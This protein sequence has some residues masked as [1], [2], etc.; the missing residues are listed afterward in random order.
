MKLGVA[1]VCLFGLLCNCLGQVPQTP[2][3]SPTL[4][5]LFFSGNQSWL[6]G[7]KPDNPSINYSSEPGLG[8]KAGAALHH[9]ISPRFFIETSLAYVWE[10][11]KYRVEQVGGNP[12]M[13]L[14]YS[15]VHTSYSWLE[16][17]V[18]LNF[19]FQHNH[20]LPFF[21]GMGISV[22]RLVNA[23]ADV[24]ALLG[25]GFTMHSTL[26]PGVDEWNFF[27]T[28]QAGCHFRLSQASRLAVAVSYQQSISN[29]YKTSDLPAGADSYFGN[30]DFRQH[31]INLGITYFT[32]LSS[33]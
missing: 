1:F 28:L 12:A 4:L 13:V 33:L 21:I 7:N 9:E 26:D 30:P 32:S 19:T 24:S 16:M 17:P 20:Q 22:R 31:S 6:T 15:D 18:I 27:P 25:N 10:Q 3:Q 2:S 8:F 14:A 11:N 23:S 29:W 5:G